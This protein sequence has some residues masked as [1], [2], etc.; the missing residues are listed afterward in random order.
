[1][2]KRARK[3]LLHLSVAS[4]AIAGLISNAALANETPAALST[5]PIIQLDTDDNLNPFYGDIGAFYGDINAF[6]GDIGAFYGDIHA[7]YGDI[8]AFWGD[9]NAFYG[10]IHAFYGDINA[11]YGDIGAFW[12][13]LNAFYGDI[14]AFWG[15]LNAFTDANAN[16][17]AQ[18][19]TQLNEFVSRSEQV[20]GAAVEAKTGESFRDGFAEDFFNRFGIELD[21][22][23][24]LAEA[25]DETR[26]K[27]FIAWH[28]ALMG[29]TGSDN[30][31]YWMSAINWSPQIAQ[32][33]YLGQNMKVGILDTALTGTEIIGG[34]LKVSDGY[35]IEGQQHGA[36]VASLIAAAHDGK[37][38]MGVSPN[39]EL[40]LSNPF[41][42]TGTAGW[43]DVRKGIRD[44]G[45]YG[46]SVINF[47][48]GISGWTLSQ[49]WADNVFS[50]NDVQKE[51]EKVVFVKAA[52]ND[53]LA[54]SADL[55]WS[56][57][58]KTS[59]K[60]DYY[61]IHGRLLIVG[62]VNPSGEISSFSNTPGDACL[63][64][65]GQCN[66]G[67]RLMDRFLVAP[68]ELL[69]VSDNAGDLT[70]MSGTSFAAPLVSGTVALVQNRWSWLKDFPL[71]TSD[72]ILRSARDLG[73]PGVDPVYGHGL[74]DV[75]ATMR[76]L[77][78]AALTINSGGSDYLLSGMG[79]TS[80]A[81][82]LFK[83]QAT[84]TAFESIG[85][86]Y[87]DFE[88]RVEDLT[89]APE[90][91][92]TEAYLEH[93]ISGASAL[94]EESVTE[95][96]KK[97]NKKKKRNK[98]KFTDVRSLSAPLAGEDG[99]SF[100]MTATNYAPTEQHRT[101]GVGFDSGFALQNAKTGFQLKVGS[102]AGAVALS[103]QSGFGM[104]SDYAVETGGVN[105]V[106]GLASGGAYASIGYG[107]GDRTRVSFG[108]TQNRDEHTTIDPV[109]LQEVNPLQGFDDYQASALA[110][111]IAY[112]VNTRMTVTA[113]FA[114]LTEDTGLLGVQGSSALSLSGGAKTSAATF[115]AEIEAARSFTVS[116]SATLATTDADSFQG[117][118]VSVADG[119]LKSSAFQVAVMKSGVL[120]ENDGLRMSIAQPL[121][122]EQGALEFESMAVV[123]RTTGELGV[124]TQRW[125]LSGGARDMILDVLY[126][127][128][129]MD[130]Q[131]EISAFTQLEVDAN[132]L[133]EKQTVSFGS[134]FEFKF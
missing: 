3:N 130:G 103:N 86:T 101:D 112:D 123:D 54:Q 132:A 87:R 78:P 23:E 128:P 29:F 20:W 9:L 63:L 107:L 10:D 24:S 38:V 88:V 96:A 37:G 52:G 46:S 66:E 40:F 19:Q 26:A 65:N 125:D 77:D 111:D 22:A 90:T 53:G 44:L 15:D 34:E 69:L 133:A 60:D 42:E 114:D 43:Q 16:D 31:D 121:R 100:S 76:P 71:E 85:E 72:I 113:G 105:P 51:V 102:G 115:G 7:F 94:V 106:L 1:M 56:K 89:I 14:H 62:S 98:K 61:A 119:G 12:G 126:A 93:Q 99:W 32:D 84:I 81:K 70:R 28:D 129:V 74:L 109:S 116:A 122:I 4:C 73:D 13:D 8:H 97:K 45:N 59:N 49:E 48:L 27:I 11:F 2:G 95:P 117:S 58:V 33:A 6:Y 92:T 120:G 47:S 50:K 18:L 104:F 83:N 118:A 68:G 35:N 64:V 127:T 5:A 36:A 110:I 82:K 30:I 134:R 131:A 21:D 41:D 108:F 80:E 67:Y 17:Y 55:D 91:D 75:A 124:S 25:S 57:V 79:L 39:V